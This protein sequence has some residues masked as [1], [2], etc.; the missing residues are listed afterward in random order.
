MLSLFA[1][2]CWSSNQFCLSFFSLCFHNNN[3]KIPQRLRAVT[4]NI[5]FSLPL[6]RAVEGLILKHHLMLKLSGAHTQNTKQINF[7]IKAQL[8]CFSSFSSFIFHDIW[9]LFSSSVLL[10]SG[11]RSLLFLWR[12]HQEPPFIFC[13][14]CVLILHLTRCE[15]FHFLQLRLESECKI[16]TNLKAKILKSLLSKESLVKKVI[17]KCL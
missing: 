10:I 1:S 11:S 14:A 3:K 5:A 4:G 13:R 2:T 16:Q 8:Y 6:N 7:H 15:I 9:W 12:H 17:C